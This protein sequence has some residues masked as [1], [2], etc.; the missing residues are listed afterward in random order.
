MHAWRT[1][2]QTLGYVKYPSFVRTVELAGWPAPPFLGGAEF[3]TSL[4][5][6]PFSNAL[7]IQVSRQSQAKNASPIQSSIQL[8]ASRQ[9]SW[10]ESRPFLL[11]LDWLTRREIGKSPT[12][13][14]QDGGQ[15]KRNS[16]RKLF[17]V[18]FQ[19]D[20]WYHSCCWHFLFTFSCLQIDRFVS[21]S[22]VFTLLYHLIAWLSSRWSL[23]PL[24]YVDKTIP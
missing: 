10:R 16:Q 20:Q 23:E 8:H 22:L 17:A 9:T 21:F 11:L 6:K 14:F 1:Y 19:C 5:N 24:I 4:S 15:R 3:F 2:R 7:A 12:R 18:T 13:I